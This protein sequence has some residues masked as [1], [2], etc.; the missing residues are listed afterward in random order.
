MKVMTSRCEEAELP[1]EKFNSTM[2]P[3]ENS[4]QSDS[5]LNSNESL[6]CNVIGEGDFDDATTQDAADDESS[7]MTYDDVLNND[8]DLPLLCHNKRKRFLIEDDDSIL[9]RHKSLDFVHLLFPTR[10]TS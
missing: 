7:N 6:N 5:D 2:L 1:D 8:D 4:Y 9:N 10:V 3:T